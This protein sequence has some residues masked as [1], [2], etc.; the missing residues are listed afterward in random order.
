MAS[1]RLL[2]WMSRMRSVPQPER[3]I[4]A[5][6][7][8]HGSPFLMLPQSSDDEVFSNDSKLGGLHYQFL[9]QLGPFLL[10]KFK[11]KGIIV[12]S[13]H[14]ESRGSVEVYSRD[15]ENPLFYD[16]YGFPDYLYQIKFHSKG[17]KRIADQI[18]SALKE[19]QIPAKTV[20]GDRGL[21]HG[22]FV[23]FK[24]MF[25]DGLNIPLIEVSMHTL[26]PMQLYKVGQA[27]QSLRKEYLIVSG[28]LNIHTFEDLSAFNEDTAAD[29]YKE[30]QLDILK[31][32]E[33]DKQNDRLNKLLGLQ[34]HPYFRKAHPRE[35]H[36]VP[37]YVAAGLGSS[38]KSKVVCDLYG[39]V[40]A[41][42][43]ID[44]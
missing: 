30:F 35:E 27:L 13:A 34:L 16:Y 22:V 3:L 19:Y 17:S 10:E 36:F 7:L 25:P 2:D 14:Y 12:F 6:Y 32:I 33:T 24:I 5:L 39:A 18:I 1:S 11:P 26:D 38:G 15:D 21:D 40:S 31:A 23:P 44:E 42:F 43:G 41:F 37:L 29:G 20:S 28:G 4:P 9:E 8:A